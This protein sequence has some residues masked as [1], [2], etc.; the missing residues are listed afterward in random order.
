MAKYTLDQLARMI[1]HTNLKAD[2]LPADLEKLCEEAKQYHFA[3]VAINQIQSPTC[4][5]FLAGTDIKVGAAIAFP[6][7]Q[8]SIEAKAF[9]TDNAL[10]IGASEIDYVI[11][12][13][14]AREG[15]WDYIKREMEVVVEV[16][17]K[18]DVISKVIFENC[19]LTD[20]QKIK[21]CEIAS[22]VKPDF[23]KTSTGMATGGATLED[24]A[25]MRK[26]VSEEVQV[27]ASGGVRTADM[28]LSML[29]NGVTR[30][31][32]SSGIAIIEEIKERF[33]SN[34]EEYL[35]I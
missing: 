29:R 11:H 27:K 24:V 23:I 16:C 25:L 34:G 1:D 13:G 17:R 15:D 31:G 12:I 7:G 30:V 6:L 22:V 20:E 14:K 19:Y 35:E 5:K 4:A 21:L 3:M 8:T 28:F 2:A 18:H 9:E 32:S 26:H 33:F 10:S